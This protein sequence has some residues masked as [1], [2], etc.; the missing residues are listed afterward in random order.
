MERI[1]PLEAPYPPGVGQTLAAMM[2]PGV[3]PSRRART[4]R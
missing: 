1:A 4:I 3:E 2:P